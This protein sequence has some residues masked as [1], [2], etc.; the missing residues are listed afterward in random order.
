MSAPFFE[1]VSGPVRASKHRRVAK[2]ESADV[3]ATYDRE[4][5]YA[6]ENNFHYPQFR[7]RDP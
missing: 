2:G 6:I 7:M 1:R 5:H 4:P 3:F